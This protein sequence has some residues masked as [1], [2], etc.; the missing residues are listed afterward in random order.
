MLRIYFWFIVIFSYILRLTVKTK[1]LEKEFVH[2]INS[3][4]G[5]LYKICNLYCDEA[6]DRKDLFQEIVL[7]LWKSYPKFRNESS[8][9]TWIYRIGLNTAISNFRKASQKIYQTSMQDEVF[10]VPDP[11]Q[12]IQDNEKFAALHQ[13]IG[14]LNIIEKALIMLYLEEKSYEEMAAILGIS[15]SNVGVKLNR[16][17]SNLEKT[18]KTHHYES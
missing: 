6:E 1:T 12:F 8:I 10:Q 18:I 11:D 14:K 9:S 7:Q 3:H 4:R 5:L 17:K 16:I 15:K 2:I 13:A